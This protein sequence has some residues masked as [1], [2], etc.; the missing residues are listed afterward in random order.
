IGLTDAQSQSSNDTADT[1]AIL[2]TNGVP[3]GA[4]NRSAQSGIVRYRTGGHR[5]AE[6]MA[7]SYTNSLQLRGILRVLKEQKALDCWDVVAKTMPAGLILETMNFSGG[8]NLGLSGTTPSDQMSAISDFYDKLLTSE[9]NGQ[10][11]FQTSAEGAPRTQLAP[12]SSTVRWSFDL[13][14]T[15]GAP[16]VSETVDPQESAPAAPASSDIARELIGAWILVGTPGNIGPVPNKGGRIKFYTGKYYCMT[17]SDPKNGVVNYHHGGTYTVNGNDYTETVQYANPSTMDFIGKTNGHFNI[18]I[19]GDTM[20]LIG[21]DNPWK[22]VWKKRT[23]GAGSRSEMAREMTGMWIR[24]GA[25]LTDSTAGATL[26]FITPTDWCFTE[27]DA[28][29]GVVTFHHGGTCTFNGDEYVESVKY[30]NP[31]TMYLLGQD[32]KFACKLDGDTLTTT[33]IGN[34]WNEVWKRAK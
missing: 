6:D 33:G 28:K 31:S 8:T 11:L 7:Q 3:S 27:S 25:D 5:Q 16:K 17:A 1:V 12:G 19:E 10:L 4:T 15:E 32:N 9:K 20:T 2:V 29:T 21:I 24:V 34:P 18:S 26:K 23:G 30:A 22:E 14:L 13:D